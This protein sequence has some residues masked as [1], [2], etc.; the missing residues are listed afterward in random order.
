MTG[1]L[2][3]RPEA[4]PLCGPADTIELIGAARGTGRHVDRREWTYV[5]VHRSHGLWTHVYDV[6]HLPG[7]FGEEIRLIRVLPGDR[8]AEARSWALAVKGKDLAD[9]A[10]QGDSSARA[11]NAIHMTRRSKNKR[12]FGHPTC[13]AESIDICRASDGAVYEGAGVP[14]DQLCAKPSGREYRETQQAQLTNA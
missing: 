11:G 5:A 4:M 3:L 12:S 1:H 6:V 7:A 10:E 2:E 8:R 14:P 9:T 13:G